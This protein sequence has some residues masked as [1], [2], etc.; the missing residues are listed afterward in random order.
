MLAPKY[1]AQLELEN[2]TQDRLGQFNG[3]HFGDVNVGA[4]LFTRKEDGKDFV[5]LKVWSAPG[6]TKPS[7]A[8]AMKQEFKEAKKGDSF[9]DLDPPLM[10]TV[11]Q[12]LVE[13][14]FDPGCEAMIFTT[15]GTPV[16][17]ITGGFG[18]DRRVEYIIPEAARKAGVHEL[19]IESSCNGM[20][21]MAG[22]GIGPP[23]PNRY[24][25]LEMADLVVPNMEAWRLLWDFHTLRELNKALIAA[26]AIL[27]AFSHTDPASI[28]RARHIAED[29]FG[30]GWEA[31]S[32]GV[33]DDARGGLSLVWGIGHCHIDTAWLWPYSATQQKTARSWATQ[34]DLMERYPEHRFPCSQAQ[35]YKW[36]EQVPIPPALRAPREAGARGQVPPHRRFVGREHANMPSGEALVRQ[37]LFGQGYFEAKFGKRCD[38]AW[39]PDSFGLTGAL[40]Q[41]IRGAGMKYFFTQK[42]SWN[43]INTFPHSTFN[44]VGIDGTQVLCHMTPVD[45]YTSTSLATVGDVNRAVKNHKNLESSLLVFGNGDGGGASCLDLP[46]CLRRMRAVT[47]THRELPPV[48]MVCRLRSLLWLRALTAV[49]AGSIKKGNR[50]SEI[51]LRD[52]EHVATLA[53]LRKDTKYKVLLNHGMVYDDAEKLYAEVRADCEQ[54]LDD[55]LEVILGSAT[56]VAPGAVASLEKIVAYNTTFFPR[57]EVARVPLGAAGDSLRNQVAQ[58]SADGKEELYMNGADHFVLRQE[59]MQL[60]ISKGRITSLVHVQQKRELIQEAATGGLVIFEDRPNFWDAWDATPLAFSNISVVAQGPLRASVCAEVKDGQSKISVT[61]CLLPF[62]DSLSTKPNSRSM[63]RFDAVVDWREHHEFLKFELPLNIYS[64]NAT[65]ETQFGHVQRPTHKNTTWDMAKFEVCG[66]K[67][68]D[69][70]EYGYGLAYLSES[71]YGFGCQG[72]IL[73]ISL[74]RAAT[75]PDSDQD[76]GEHTFS[77]AVMPHEGHFLESDVPVAAYLFNSPIHGQYSAFPSAS[78]VFLETVKRAED[79]TLEAG[80]RRTVVLCLYEAFGGH[81][82]TELRIASELS[83]EAVYLTNLLEDSAE[84]EELALLPPMDLLRGRGVK[85]VKLV[86]GKGKSHREKRESWVTVDA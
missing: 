29:V 10:S 78:N 20:F 81:A 12:P 84:D 86:L 66:H 19:I 5:D 18:G 56:R 35:Q 3:G 26:N 51:L 44:W 27:K 53:S 38:T 73:R 9:N 31:L 76:Q 30:E 41:L 75:E 6:L 32:A 8:E 49:G 28:G 47:N 60:T 15:D 83:V 65:Y 62:L 1:S 7:F 46:S 23:D 24:F 72:N 11:D 70:S 64:D 55:A 77:W 14:E 39:L 34:L 74:L 25:R 45:T 80:G 57:R 50:H 85:M 58:R 82:Y 63:F 52:V 48:N 36:L 13:V 4:V 37:L 42:L 16:H 22:G 67:Y 59:S 21:G 79:D 2:L 54:M 68:A 61:V 17:G 40:P 69:L 43:K 71:N 33:H